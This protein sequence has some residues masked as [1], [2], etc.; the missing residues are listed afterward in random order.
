MAHG[1][2]AA[3]DPVQPAR[4]H[5]QIDGAPAEPEREQL[6]SRDDPVL[7]GG[8]VSDEAIAPTLVR[9]FIYTS[10]KCTSVGHDAIL[11]GPV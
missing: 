11:D 8:Q 6:L 1:V 10:A 3:V 5:S 2:D 4:S 9:F 7:P